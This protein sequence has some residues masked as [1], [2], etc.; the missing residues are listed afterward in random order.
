M[1]ATTAT[2]KVKVNDPYAKAVE[3]LEATKIGSKGYKKANATF[4][5]LLTAK[6]KQERS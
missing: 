4:F 5:A 3:V 6:R 1:T 2:P